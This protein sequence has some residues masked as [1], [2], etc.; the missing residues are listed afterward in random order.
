VR[1]DVE[2]RASSQGPNIHANKKGYQ[3]LANAFAAVD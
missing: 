3:V 1:L 2:L